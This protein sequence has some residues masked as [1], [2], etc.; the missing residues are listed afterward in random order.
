MLIQLTP[1]RLELCV[2][3]LRERLDENDRAI[4]EPY[5]ER[6]ASSGAHASELA[7]RRRDERAA[8][9]KRPA[10]QLDQA[11]DT[12]FRALIFGRRDS[13]PCRV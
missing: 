6:A 3:L 5:A 4:L 11:L 8:S 9:Y 7:F 10:V 1:G 13:A 2:R 12:T